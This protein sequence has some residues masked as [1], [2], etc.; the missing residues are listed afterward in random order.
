MSHYLGGFIVVIL[1]G[2]GSASPEEFQLI[3]EAGLDIFTESSDQI[4]IE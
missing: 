2:G 4:L 1:Y 3:T